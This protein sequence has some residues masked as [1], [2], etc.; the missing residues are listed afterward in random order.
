[1]PSAV[2]AR[3]TR[4]SGRLYLFRTYFHPPSN[5]SCG[6]NHGVPIWQVARATSAAPTY[7]N[8][9]SINKK[10]FIDGGMGSNNLS[11]V[12]CKEV[13][14]MDEYLKTFQKQPNYQSGPQ[15][16]SLGIGIM[17][18]IGSGKSR[19]SEKSYG[20]ESVTHE[21]VARQLKGATYFR[22]NVDNGLQ[23]IRF[24]ECEMRVVGGKRINVTLDKIRAA[25]ETYLAKPEVVALIRNCAKELVVRRR[26]HI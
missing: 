2:I 9:I 8:P 16:Q 20:K 25:T 11:M 24:D 23:D 19:I 13:E 10:T 4:G 5:S 3:E 1:M 6:I 22:L 21:D 17:V 26:P 12:A 7:F 18:S 15:I 14:S